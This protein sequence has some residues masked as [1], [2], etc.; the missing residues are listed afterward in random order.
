MTCLSI[1]SVTPLIIGSNSISHDKQVKFDPYVD[2][3]GT[4]IAI[5]G[6]NFVAIGADTR[7]PEGYVI[8]SRRW[9]RLSKVCRHT[10]LYVAVF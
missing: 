9:S 6:E 2:N 1:E 5:A 8:R 3:G 7:L 4:V 10:M